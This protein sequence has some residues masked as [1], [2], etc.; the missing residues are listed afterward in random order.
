MTD[1]VFRFSRYDPSLRRAD[2]RYP[3][4]TWTELFELIDEYKD[5]AM[6]KAVY[7]PVEDAYVEAV[8]EI[9][10][11]YCMNSVRITDVERNSLVAGLLAEAGCDVQVAEPIPETIPV[12]ALS[13]IVRSALRGQLWCQIRS[14]RVDITFGQDLYM[15]VRAQNSCEAAQRAVTMFGLF[16]GDADYPVE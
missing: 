3:E 9:L 16:V 12:N 6:A 4:G 5:I 14:S 2:G 7:E 13:P 1:C 11:V 15:Y 10:R 8:I